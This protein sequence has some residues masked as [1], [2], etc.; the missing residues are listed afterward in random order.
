MTQCYSDLVLNEKYKKKKKCTIPPTPQKQNK[1]KLFPTWIFNAS[2]STP[3]AWEATRVSPPLVEPNLSSFSS[4][5]KVSTGDLSSH[6]G[7]D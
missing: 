2:P 7:E 1:T 4:L 3:E 5:C 6:G